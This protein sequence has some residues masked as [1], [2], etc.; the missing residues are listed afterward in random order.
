MVAVP[1]VVNDAVATP[2]APTIETLAF[3][4]VH[5]P[6]E[7]EEL[8][9]CE[10]PMQIT[11]LPVIVAGKGFTVTVTGSDEQ[12]TSL[13]TIFAVPPATPYTTPPK[14]TSAFEVSLDTH[15]P[16]VVVSVSV[17][18]LPA[19]NGVVP[20]VIA[21]GVTFPIFRERNALHPPPATA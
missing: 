7:G 2:V 12:P 3:E 15:A 6:P 1:T 21:L 20:P 14:V 10:L 8:K 18:V 5:T 17:V 19:Q 16:P 4:L 11:P 13:Y 9:V